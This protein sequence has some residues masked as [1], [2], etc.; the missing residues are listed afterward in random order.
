MKE[1]TTKIATLAGRV[2]QG[3]KPTRKEIESLAASAL[4]QAEAE[5][6]SVKAWGIERRN[7]QLLGFTFNTNKGARAAKEFSEIVIPVEIRRV[8]PARADKRKRK[9]G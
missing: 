6:E 5:Q 3:H 1:T 7:G 9:R 4:A 2:L 8:R